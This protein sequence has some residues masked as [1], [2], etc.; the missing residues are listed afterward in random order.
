[1]AIDKFFQPAD[2]ITIYSSEEGGTLLNAE[3]IAKGRARV[4]AG[5]DLEKVALEM[6]QYEVDLIDPDMSYEDPDFE[7]E[8]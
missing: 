1:M 4:A 5:E 8:S 2:G 3:E 6:A 7:E